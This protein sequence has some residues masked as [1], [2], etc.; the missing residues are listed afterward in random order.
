MDGERK[1][2]IKKIGEMEVEGVSDMCK[3]LEDRD[4]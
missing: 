3:N 2:V 4:D 1:K